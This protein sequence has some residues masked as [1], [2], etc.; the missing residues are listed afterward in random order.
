MFA[1]ARRRVQFVVARRVELDDDDN[2]QCLRTPNSI[3][4][5]IGTNVGLPNGWLVRVEKVHRPY[6]NPRLPWPR[7]GSARPAAP[8]GAGIQQAGTPPTWR[9]APRYG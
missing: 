3:P 6:M 5:V 2:N 1:H 9:L 7:G 8:G 4:F